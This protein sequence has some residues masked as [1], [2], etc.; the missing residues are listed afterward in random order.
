MPLSR[1]EAAALVEDLRAILIAL[2]AGELESSTA[3]WLE[4]YESALKLFA[5]G[6]FL[7]Q[8]VSAGNKDYTKT[9]HSRVS[10]SR[11]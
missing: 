3:H 9:Y 4:A 5:A 7:I 11:C 1:A 10:A 8:R 2:E 6:T